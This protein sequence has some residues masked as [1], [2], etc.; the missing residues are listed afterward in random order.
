MS[1]IVRSAYRVEKR[2]LRYIVVRFSHWAGR[3]LVVEKF[4]TRK[5]AEAWAAKEG[6]EVVFYV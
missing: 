3:D 2:G 5:A 6:G 1:Q 4:W